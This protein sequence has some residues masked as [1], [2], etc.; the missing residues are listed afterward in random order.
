MTVATNVA[1][2]V[3]ATVAASVRAAAPALAA[4][5]GGTA[6]AHPGHHA[7]PAMGFFEGLQHLLTQPDHVALLALAVGMAVVVAR[8]ARAARRERSRRGGDGR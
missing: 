4:F 3:A 5:A 1:A 8:R 6:I 2:T 7:A